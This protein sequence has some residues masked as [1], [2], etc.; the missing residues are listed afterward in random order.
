MKKVGIEDFVLAYKGREPSHIGYY[1]YYSVLVPLVEKDGQLH[2]LYEVRS[3]NLTKQPG[4]VCFPG[5][6]IEKDET[7]EQ[8]AIRETSEELNISESDIKIIAPMDYMHTYSNFTM[9][10]FLGTIDYEILQKTRVNHEEVKEIFM[11]PVE[12]LLKMEPEI[13]SFNVI[14]DVG[15]DFPYEKISSTAGYNWRKG[16]SIIPIYH[17]DKWVIWGLTARITCNLIRVL[18]HK[19]KG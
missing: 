10:A 9:Y 1:S 5:G 3:D 11:V 13:Y 2:I 15:E 19:N 6:R 7:P 18:E 12:E 8:C 16:K 14:P 17:Y 4:E